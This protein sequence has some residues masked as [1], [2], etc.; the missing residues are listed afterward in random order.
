MTIN[1]EEILNKRGITSLETYTT[2][3]KNIAVTGISLA[4]IEELSPDNIDS[5]EFWKFC[6]NHKSFKY[7]S[8]SYGVTVEDNVEKVND[9]NF[10]LAAESG[11]LSNLAR[12]SVLDK[13]C[14]FKY[15]ILDIG[16]GYGMLKRHLETTYPKNTIYTGVDV[17]PKFEGVIQVTDCILPSEVMNQKFNFVFAINTFQHLSTRQRLSYYEQIKK[18][19]CD[20]FFAMTMVIDSLNNPLGFYCNDN[21]RRYMCHYGQFTLIPTYEELISEISA[22]FTVR[23]INFFGFNTNSVCFQLTEK[24]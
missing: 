18:I 10:F 24:S 16:A 9:M 23:S 7:D 1:F 11:A 13:K 2:Y 3:K 14:E 21:K 20:G 12:I 4:D 15:Q 22:Y 8:I 19:L 17:Y 5:T 6:D